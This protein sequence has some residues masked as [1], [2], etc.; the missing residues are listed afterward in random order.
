MLYGL[1]IPIA[2]K[3]LIQSASCDSMIV[4]DE[5]FQQLNTLLR[6][7]NTGINFNPVAGREND[8]FDNFRTADEVF[9][10]GFQLYLIEGKLFPD[11]HRRGLMV[12]SHENK[13]RFG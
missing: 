7:F 13:I 3:I 4:A 6:V 1:V 2:V 10:R 9:Q 12:D 11:F 5:I 8:V